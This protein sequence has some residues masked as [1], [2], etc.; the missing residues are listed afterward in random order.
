[1]KVR[2]LSLLV[3]TDRH[4]RPVLKVDTPTGRRHITPP[5]LGQLKKLLES[6]RPECPDGG[7]CHHRCAASCFRVKTCSPLS[8]V[9]PDDR[10][11][12]P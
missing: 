10:W 12:A 3:Y 6:I 9:Y 5:E 2:P 11:P 4:D 1:M 7:R 8:G